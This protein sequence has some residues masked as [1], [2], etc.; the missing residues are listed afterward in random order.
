V[1]AGQPHTT[2]GT[3]TNKYAPTLPPPNL[4]SPPRIG[5]FGARQLPP[6][7]E[8]AQNTEGQRLVSV[9]INR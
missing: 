2:Y 3:N 4:I 5:L 6:V 8:Q 9:A 7:W 1:Q